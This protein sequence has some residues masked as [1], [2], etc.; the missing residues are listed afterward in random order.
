MAGSAFA[1]NYQATGPILELTDSKIVIEKGKEK[2]SFTRTPEMKV[3]GDLK[4]GSKVTIE[5]TMTA[6]SATVKADK[7]VEKPTDKKPAKPDATKPDEKAP[8]VPKK[9]AA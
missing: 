7:A 8:A 6:V 3:T 1:E 9:K 2:W 4:V 5:Y